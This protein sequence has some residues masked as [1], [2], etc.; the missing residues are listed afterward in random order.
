MGR[1]FSSLKGSCQ[2]CFKLCQ[3][4]SKRF[5]QRV[6]IV[7]AQRHLRFQSLLLSVLRLPWSSQ[8][9]RSVERV[10]QAD[11]SNINLTGTFDSSI[12]AA[13]GARFKHQK[14]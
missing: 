3:H 8:A 14:Q 10:F 2:D 9:M 7:A 11:I 5:R 13:C 6:R 1:L 4:I 12:G